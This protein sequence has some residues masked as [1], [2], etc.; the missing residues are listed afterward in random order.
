M[1]SSRPVSLGAVMFAVLATV[2]RIGD[3][4]AMKKRG[5]DVHHQPFGA[6]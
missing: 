6:A 1:A 5:F 4:L 3:G 2:S